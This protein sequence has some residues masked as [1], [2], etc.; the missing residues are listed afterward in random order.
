MTIFSRLNKE[1][2]GKSSTFFC[3]L[4]GVIV[5][6]R[7]GFGVTIPLPVV[8][9][10]SLAVCLTSL[11]SKPAVNI[12]LVSFIAVY[13]TGLA[14]YPEP[15]LR[16]QR[17]IAF[18]IGL[19]CFSPL[20]QSCSMIKS[21]ELIAKTLY[22]ALSVM[23]MLSFLTWLICMAVLGENGIWAMN[24]YCY[25]F[26]GVFDIG[27]ILSSVAAMVAVISASCLLRDEKTRWKR[28]A[29][30]IMLVIGVVMC[31]VGGSRTAFVGLSVS[32]LAFVFFNRKS[33][34][35]ILRKPVAITISLC[36]LLAIAASLP[37]AMTI[38]RYKNSI[39]ESH[40]SIFYSREKLWN[41]R[42]EEFSCSPVIGIGYAN[43]LPSGENN[44][45]DLREI[46][47]GSSW[48][49]LL[50]YGGII[51]AGS[52]LWF[53]FLLIRRLY[54]SRH[55][56]RSPLLSSLLI[57]LLINATTEGWLMFSGGLMFPLFWLT[58]SAIWTMGD[59]HTLAEDFPRDER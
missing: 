44:H 11:S 56:R 9:V 57:F 50:S 8:S 13:G 46:E 24:F 30:A 18:V 32:M 23:V 39:G 31:A 37:A 20:L 1:R 54:K 41:D 25:G 17:F 26:R 49:S 7:H 48:L 12:P 29:Y 53:F 21:R 33:I 34:A 4:L 15:W 43:E 2:L 14:V 52:F 35:R 36:G 38:I 42:L 47:P 51:G 10:L 3:V 5:C 22:V 19:V 40:G 28:S 58:T 27:I 59:N 16:C 6:L 55:D 45:G